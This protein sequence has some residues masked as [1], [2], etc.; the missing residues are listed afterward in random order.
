MNEAQL[1]ITIGIIY[2]KVT[3]LHVYVP[4]T[5][6]SFSHCYAVAPS[7]N[8]GW[9]PFFRLTYTSLYICLKGSRRP[10][11]FI[12]PDCGCV[13]VSKL[14]LDSMKKIHNSNY[15]QPYRCSHET[16]KF[17][18]QSKI[19]RYSLRGVSTLPRLVVIVLQWLLTHFTASM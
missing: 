2:Y 5:S 1:T 16:L 3:I 17:F 8:G 11:L 12:S 15:I 10:G 13:W 7:A 18:G 19:Q 4:F 14:V 6:L 9:W